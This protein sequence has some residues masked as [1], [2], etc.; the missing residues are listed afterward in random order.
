MHLDTRKQLFMDDLF[1]ERADGVRLCVNPP[2][3]HEEPV[4]LPDR[5]WEE[6]GIS[7]YN[8]VMREADGRFRMWYGASMLLGLPQE[9]AI[10]LCYAESAD[11]LHWDKPMLGLLPFRGSVDNNIVA[12]Q[13]ERQSQQGATVYRDER[14]PEA[15]RYKLWT[16]FRP[17]DAELEAGVGA[18][19]YAMHSP[20]GIHWTVYPG[21]PN[22]PEQMCDTQNMFFWDDRLELY[23]GY[24]RVRETQHIDEAAGGGRGRY[25]AIGRITSPDFRTWSDTQVVLE[26]D[27]TDLTIPLPGEKTTIRPSLDFYTSCAMKCDD[28]Q[29]VYLMFPSVYYHWQD[30]EFPATMDVQ[31]LTSRDGIAWQRT[32]DRQPFLRHG[33]DGSATSGMLFAN[34]WLI[35]VGNELWFYYKGTARRH[36]GSG[37]IQAP[38][39]IYRASLRQDGFIS[40]DAGYRGG[41]F[42][43][44]PLTFEGDRLEVNCDG[45]AAGWLKVELQTPEGCPLPEFSFDQADAVFGNALRKPV[46]W[47]AGRDLAGLAGRPVRLRF[48][49]RDMKLYAFRISCD[50]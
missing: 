45:S 7:G 17:T 25:R 40:V 10:R 22:P 47:K 34:P 26:A 28:A 3:Q 32:C 19:L 15:E 1:L 33:F 50:T 11:G 18:G 46:A 41:E 5:P 4:L 2:V 29:D 9:G 43:T 24:T 12:P 6:R 21:Q 13:L 49:M 8:T 37:D 20:D 44:P 31:L 38:S 23:V 27:D 48:V 30:G 14:A 36:S 42:T 39:G 35:P 16:K